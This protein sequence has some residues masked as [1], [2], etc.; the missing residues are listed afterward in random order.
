MTAPVS[1]SGEQ[2]GYARQLPPGRTRDHGARRDGPATMKLVNLGPSRTA[3][4]NLGQWHW[5]KS[6]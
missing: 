3:M 2:I 4:N 1:S 6:R 5:R